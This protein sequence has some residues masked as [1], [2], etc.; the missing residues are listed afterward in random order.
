MVV[1]IQSLA[2][3]KRQDLVIADYGAGQEFAFLVRRESS[4]DTVQKSL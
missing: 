4:T 2:A 1:E 3:H